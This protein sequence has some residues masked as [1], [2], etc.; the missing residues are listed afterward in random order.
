[1]IFL[2]QNRY[3]DLLHPE[4]KS[5]LQYIPFAWKI[6]CNA[7]K[8]GFSAI[9]YRRRALCLKF[10]VLLAV[11]GLTGCAANAYVPKLNITPD[12]T[13]AASPYDYGR[14][15]GQNLTLN[16]CNWGEYMSVGDPDVLDVNKEFEALTGIHVN[17]KTAATN[18]ELYA[19]LLSGGATYDIII[20]SDYM[21]SRMID[22]NLLQPLN[23]DNIPNVS[24]INDR[25]LQP[26]Y[27]P[28]N[29]YSVPYMWGIV[30]LIYN[31]EMIAD[32][33]ESWDALWNPAYANNILMFN[34][35]RDAFGIALL[36]NGF[37]INTQDPDELKIA[38]ES[39]KSQKFVVQAY[40]MDEIFDKM[41]GGS[42]AI[43]PYYAGDAVTMMEDNPDLSWAIP[44]EGTNQFVDALCIPATSAQKEAAEMYINFLNEPEVALANAEYIG[45]STPN[46]AAFALLNED[47]QNN[48]LQ[49]PD[50]T[51]LVEKTEFFY[52]LSQETNDLLQTLWTE[53]KIET[54]STFLETIAIP[55]I[56]LAGIGL[57]IFIN[58]RRAMKKRQDDLF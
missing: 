11:A 21:I 2:F 22:E 24:L 3:S 41:G 26:V 54:G 50:E 16:V 5:T 44:E 58:V 29:A 39:L 33:V 38:A 9:L 17:Y 43:A 31:T 37:S 35:P 52:N 36:K 51:Y 6:L 1:M 40:V 42:A 19:K 57:S 53:L 20:P 48:P 56:L 4:R 30:C 27:D 46:T 10:F 12:G 7:V 14:F 28:D 8:S 45:Y 47:V 34:N 32:S 49:Y 55:A 13:G 15:A 23:F 25:F 18:E